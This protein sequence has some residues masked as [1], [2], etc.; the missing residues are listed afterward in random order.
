MKRFICRTT[1]QEELPGLGADKTP[2]RVDAGDSIQPRGT[3]IAVAL[4]FYPTFTYLSDA[5]RR[6]LFLLEIR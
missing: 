6:P 1:G 5:R 2:P 4:M 3:C